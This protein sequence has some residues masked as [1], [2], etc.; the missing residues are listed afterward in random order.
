[1]STKPRV[2]IDESYNCFSGSI[3][4]AD[5]LEWFQGYVLTKNKK[6]V[7]VQMA[8]TL[9]KGEKTKCVIVLYDDISEDEPNNLGKYILFGPDYWGKTKS[10]LDNKI[11]AVKPEKKKTNDKPKKGRAS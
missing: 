3:W 5:E 10:V 2:S 9:S 7:K 8:Q 1:M 6:V 4:D 11:K